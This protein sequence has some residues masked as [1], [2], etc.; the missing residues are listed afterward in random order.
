MILEVRRVVTHK[1]G[2][3]LEKDMRG[4][5]EVLGFLFLDLGAGFMVYSVFENS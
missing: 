2:Q 1:A 5:S 4:T 3:W